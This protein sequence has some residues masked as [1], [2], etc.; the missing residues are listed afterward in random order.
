MLRKLMIYRN[1]AGNK[2]PHV[3]DLG[4]SF[5]SFKGKTQSHHY[6]CQLVGFLVL[7]GSL[8]GGVS[9]FVCLFFKVSCH[10][11]KFTPAS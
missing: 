7:G 11:V 5:T 8:R 6:K 1:R 2:G 4:K 3:T 10:L 9:L